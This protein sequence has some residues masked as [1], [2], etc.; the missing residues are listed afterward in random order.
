MT[1]VLHRMDDGY[2]G[3]VAAFLSSNT[4]PFQVNPS[5]TV[6][7]ARNMA[8]RKT[9]LRAGFVKEAHYRRAWPL[10]DGTRAASVAYAILRT[11]WE[12]NTVT[13]LDFN[14]FPAE[15]ELQ[16]QGPHR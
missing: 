3:K 16:E 10:A 6:A 4:F 11:D 15:R 9:F 5:L 14:D 2:A 8:M 13:A 12:N 7:E 1:V